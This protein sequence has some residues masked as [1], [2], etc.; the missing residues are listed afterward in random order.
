[1]AEPAAGAG[2][3]PGA[4]TRRRALGLLAT[5]AASTG[6]AACGV[7][8]R[9]TR[10]RGVPQTARETP[11]ALDEGARAIRVNIA[12]RARTASASATGGWR[13]YESDGAS[14]LVSGGDGDVWRVEQAG[15]ELRAVHADGRVSAR[16]PGPLVLRAVE[17]DALVLFGGKR[18]RGELRFHP[19]ETGVLVVNRLPLESYLRGVVPLEIG[20][21]GAADNAAVQAQAVAARSYAWMRLAVASRPWDVLATVDDQVYGGVDAETVWADYGVSSTQ[22]LVV[23]YDGRIVNAPYHSTCGGRTAQAT[24]VWRGVDGPHLRSVSDVV[25]GSSRHYCELSPR[26]E[27]TWRWSREELGRT[28][29]RNLGRYVSLPSR[30]IGRLRD[31]EIEDRTPSGR[32]RSLAVATSTGRHRLERNEIRFVLRSA[33]GEILPS[34]YFSLEADRA[35]GGEIRSLTVRGSGYGHGIGMCQWGAIGRARAGQ[36]FREILRT[37]YPGTTVAAV[38]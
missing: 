17:R 26:F 31:I 7:V 3:A 30:G 38:D 33:G 11:G 6:A 16:S 14:L 12:S 2:E 35:S 24:E 18:Y 9:R 29:V 1:L 22:G 32:V 10:E 25:E 37:Y 8:P 28:L 21:P 36:D 34:T 4:I 15:G 13:L 23:Q 19:G 5:V 27:W 20:T